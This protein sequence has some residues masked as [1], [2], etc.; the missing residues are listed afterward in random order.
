MDNPERTDFERFLISEWCDTEFCT[1]RLDGKL[2][3]VAVT[4]VVSTGLSA[5][6][7]YFDPEFDKRSLGTACI[8]KQLQLCKQR[9]LDYVYL[10]YWIEES[11]KMNYKSFYKPQ[12]RYIDDHWIKVG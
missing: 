4:D 3:A 8:M 9:G 12:E 11:S 10:G 1:L 7:T 6:Y 5:V 2:L